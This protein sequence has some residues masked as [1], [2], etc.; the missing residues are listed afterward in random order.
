MYHKANIERL[1]PTQISKILNGH[2]VRIKHG[3]G[4]EIHLSNEQH[5]KLMSAHRRGAGITVELDPY[6]LDLNQHL[7]GHSHH[8]HH[9]HA[10]KHHAHAHHAHPHHASHGEGWMMDLGKSLGKKVAPVL[11]DAGSNALKNY[12]AGSGEGIIRR[13]AVRRGRGE[14][15]LTRKRKSPSPRGRGKKH[16]KGG[17]LK[18]AGYG[19]GY[20][21][22][23][24]G[25]FIGSEFVPF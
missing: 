25:E 18:S 4:H 19:E 3:H 1:S 6:Q 9:A 2:R 16:P 21:G 17:A 15:L 8:A 7:R 14:G 24:L 13:R 22:S 20:I 23:K 12:V 5:K 10:H 11:I